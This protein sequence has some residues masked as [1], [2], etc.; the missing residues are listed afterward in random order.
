MVTLI[1]LQEDKLKKSL[2]EDL[3][4]D[5]RRNSGIRSRIDMSKSHKFTIAM[6]EAMMDGDNDETKKKG[7]IWTEKRALLHKHNGQ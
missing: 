4:L 7:E 5:H 1:K 3:Y 2:Q 6:D